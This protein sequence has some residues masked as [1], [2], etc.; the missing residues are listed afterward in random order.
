MRGASA[1]IGAACCILGS[2]GPVAAGRSGDD[3]AAAASRGGNDAASG[4]PGV[5]GVTEPPFGVSIEAA[6]CAAAIG[7]LGS[8]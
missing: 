6:C 1:E 3:G 2:D 8:G 7:G 4:R 5:T